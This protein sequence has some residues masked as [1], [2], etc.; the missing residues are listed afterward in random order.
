MSNLNIY[1]LESVGEY[2]EI[3]SVLEGEKLA[4]L[5]MILMATFFIAFELV[6]LSSF[7]NITLYLFF[8]VCVYL[9]YMEH[10][11]ERQYS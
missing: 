3:K 6:I 1:D 9:L 2:V 8:S 4:K 7:L 11:V 5:S 10:Y